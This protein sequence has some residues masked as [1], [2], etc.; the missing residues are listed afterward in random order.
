[1]NLARLLPF[2]VILSLIW[3]AGRAVFAQ[4]LMAQ[5][6]LALE[7]EEQEAWAATI[8]L[9]LPRDEAP[10]YWGPDGTPSASI[11]GVP[12]SMRPLAWWERHTLPWRVM[13][14]VALHEP[15]GASPNLSLKASDSAVSPALT[16]SPW[17]VAIRPFKR[18]EWTGYKTVLRGG[19][20]TESYARFDDLVL[21]Y[22]GRELPIRFGSRREM[23]HM[24]A[25]MK[26]QH[27]WWQWAQP[28]TLLDS[29]DLKLVRVGG[30]LYNE[31]TFHQCD[32]YLELF[33]NGVARVSAHFVN[34]RVISD[35]WEYYGIPVIGL[36]V[37]SREAEVSLDGTRNRFEF[38]GVKLDVSDMAE[39]VSPAY[40]GRLYV[41]EGMTVY[42]PWRDQRVS[43][44]HKTYRQPFV[45]DIGEGKVPKGM[46]RTVRFTVSL[47][48]AP[49]KVAHLLAPSWLY[50][51]SDSLWH[52]GY[53]P[54]TWRFAQT[55][56]GL[57]TNVSATDA[58]VHGTYEGGFRGAAS[59]GM[60]G[61]CLTEGA[62]FT[63]DPRFLK[64]A[65][66][67]IYNWADIMVDHVDWSVR[68]P[69]TGYYWKTISYF[70]FNDL[71][72][73]YLE[74]GD[75]YLLETAEHC[76]NAY[77]AMFRSLWPIRSVGRGAW[78][79]QGLIDLYATTR[80]PYYLE[81]ALDILKKAMVTY[82]DPNDLPGHQ[83]G[84]G[85]NGIG[86]KSEPGDQGF[87]ELVLAA[88]AI[89]VAQEDAPAVITPQDRERLYDFAE[90]ILA[91]VEESL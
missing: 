18:I 47:S 8:S 63:G 42:Q 52:G 57:V 86:N 9:P 53:L 54:A 27:D 17:D 80:N 76:G 22:K 83:M 73:G 16:S 87:A 11:N 31:D 30:L 88:M 43:D 39:L 2:A 5:V 50:G 10:R 12:A 14:S 6:P 66:A 65:L 3:L 62:M 64:P 70:K 13:V 45:T 75:P 72:W 4:P 29:A 85:P 21:T 44:F 74:T 33:G 90:R 68:Q 84:V 7:A 28:E 59:E 71:V 51:M 60:G 23:F 20:H 24:S 25:A 78:P 15:I 49:P 35:G 36:G 41:H 67:Y 19:S 91:I 34:A 77:H 48:A 56:R 58:R 61:A 82:Q 40:P 46:A 69:F 32:I 38:D 37:E 79:V 55:V 89:A 81:S 1:M 26:D